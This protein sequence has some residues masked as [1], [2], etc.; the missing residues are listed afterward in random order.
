METQILKLEAPFDYIYCNGEVG[1]HIATYIVGESRIGEDGKYTLETHSHPIV[2][3]KDSPKGVVWNRAEL[4]DCEVLCSEYDMHIEPFTFCLLCNQIA[5]QKEKADEAK[6]EYTGSYDPA[7]EAEPLKKK[8]ARYGISWR[9]D[10]D[11][12]DYEISVEVGSCHEGYFAQSLFPDSLLYFN[13]VEPTLEE[14]AKR[15]TEER[16]WQEELFDHTIKI[17][18]VPES[19]LAIGFVENL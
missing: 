9:V 5:E 6:G 10:N 16:E 1:K 15:L 17:H 2:Q 14:L 12:K 7:G 19:S 3:Y 13:Y 8:L 4:T 18:Y 11:D